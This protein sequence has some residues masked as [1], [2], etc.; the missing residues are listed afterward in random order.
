MAL[1][2]H[3]P[4]WRLGMW[5]Y[6]TVSRK[7]GFDNQP[8]DHYVP[9]KEE[10]SYSDDGAFSSS[11]LAEQCPDQHTP[12]FNN[13]DYASLAAPLHHCHIY[14]HICMMMLEIRLRNDPVGCESKPKK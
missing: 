4:H 8:R 12:D 11:S 1:R 13:N 2:H 7:P 9:S 3:H 14:H 6:L 10:D 5:K